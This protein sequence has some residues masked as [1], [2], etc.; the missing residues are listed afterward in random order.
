MFVLCFFFFKQK[1]AYE[2]RTSDWSSDVCS[3]DL[4]PRARRLIFWRMAILLHRPKTRMASPGAGV[5]GEMR[6]TGRAQGGGPH[7]KGRSAAEEPAS[8][9]LRTAG[10]RPQGSAVHSRDTGHATDNAAARQN[11]KTVEEGK[12]VSGRVHLSVCGNLQKNKKTTKT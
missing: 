10:A 11:T 2:M 8:A 6:P 4:S 3:S 9:G 5:G 7:P 1:T 12:R